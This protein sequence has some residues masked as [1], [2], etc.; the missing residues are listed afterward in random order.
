MEVVE[1]TKLQ[2][3]LDRIDEEYED[4]QKQIN[5][6]QRKKDR[7]EKEKED[8]IVKLEREKYHGM[9]QVEYFKAI[10]GRTFRDGDF[11]I[12]IG[13]RC[14]YVTVIDDGTKFWINGGVDVHK[15]ALD[16][17]KSVDGKIKHKRYHRI[18]KDKKEIY[19]KL[20]DIKT[21]YGKM[22]KNGEIEPKQL[23]K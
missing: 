16:V 12:G 8:V 22:M 19:D 7:L 2:T 1:K 9:T 14:V 18:P 21:K 3:E 15:V 6:L 10:K 23:T 4:V 20:T 13:T 5:K 11:V 17:E